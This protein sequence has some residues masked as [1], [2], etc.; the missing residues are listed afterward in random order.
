MKLGKTAL[1]RLAIDG[2]PVKE[3]F[4]GVTL[5]HKCM[6]CKVSL[7][8]KHCYSKYETPSVYIKKSDKDKELHEEKLNNSFCRDCI[9]KLCLL[10][11]IIWK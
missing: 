1:G 8:G 10:A 5:T 7:N 9:D 3:Y 6:G 11:G 2:F 4:M